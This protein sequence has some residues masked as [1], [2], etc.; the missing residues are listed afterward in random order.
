MAAMSNETAHS[1]QR[2]L[3]DSCTDEAAI[4]FF[5][6]D[7]TDRITLTDFMV[8]QYD[9]FTLTKPFTTIHYVRS[10]AKMNQFEFFKAT[11]VRSALLKTGPAGRTAVALWR[12]MKGPFRRLRKAA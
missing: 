6:K 1:R 3:K 5:L 2:F 9:M 4:Y 12:A 10:R 8:S 7:K 11:W